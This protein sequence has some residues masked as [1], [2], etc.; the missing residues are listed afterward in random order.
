M[1]ALNSGFI[2]MVVPFVNISVVK[3]DWFSPE[4]A[5]LRADYKKTFT[6]V[7]PRE[8][9]IKILYLMEKSVN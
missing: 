5:L 1:V 7:C 4:I 6:T 9:E 8:S 3:K 2:Q